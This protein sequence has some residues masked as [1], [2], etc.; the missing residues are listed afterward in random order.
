VKLYR[1]TFALISYYRNY[2]N[3]C[4]L[5]SVNIWRKDP[6]FGEPSTVVGEKVVILPGIEPR[7]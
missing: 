2:S 5:D 1:F 6:Q 3:K 7:E 4:V